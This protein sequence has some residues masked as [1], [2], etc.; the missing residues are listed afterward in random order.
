MPISSKLADQTE[1]DQIWPI[2]ITDTENGRYY[3]TYGIGYATD[4][5]IFPTPQTNKRW[6]RARLIFKSEVIA[7]GTIEDIDSVDSTLKII[8]SKEAKGAVVLFLCKN[9]EICNA[10]HTAL[11][12]S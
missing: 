10:L 1:Y 12:I 5:S 7:I 8:L 9:D 2:F 3:V 4:T 11:N 6:E